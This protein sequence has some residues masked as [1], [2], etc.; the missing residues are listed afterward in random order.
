MRKDGKI[1]KI[2]FSRKRL[3]WI[4]DKY[5]NEGNYLSAL[6]MAYKE[7]DTFGGDGEVFVRLSDI[8]EGMNLQGMA[9]N[10]WF[11][12]LDIAE[13]DDLPDIYE[14]LAVNFLTLGQES[15]SA[16][17]YNRLIDADDTI[18]DETKLDIA[19]AFSTT[20]REK[21]RFVYP[22]HLAD[23]SKEVTIGAKALK[24]GDCERAVKELSKVEKGS[25][26]Y[27]QAKEMQAVAYLLASKVD[28][29][30]KACEEILS[31]CPDD[32]RA[33]ATLAAVYLEQGRG[34]KSKEIARI[35]S[36]KS[37]EDAD[38]LYKIA[39]V[40]C[41]N[42]LHEEAYQKFKILDKKTP[43]DGRILYFKGVS[44]Y[45][46]GRLDGAIAAF[47]TL[48][49]IYP[50]AEVAKY[51]LKQ[52]KECKEEGGVA[53]ELIYF[54]HLP[55]E[56]REQRCRA[57][58]KIGK[59]S[60]DEAQLFGLLAL[61]D[62][63]FR[64]CF[65]EMDGGDHELQYLGLV[66][67]IHVRAD[68]FVQD[69]LLDYEVADV[70][71]LEALRI[72]LERNEESEWGL[73]LCNIYKKVELLKVTLGRK[74]RKKF[75]EAYARLASKFVVIKDSYGA[76]IKAAT[77]ALY[78]ALENYGSLDL[79]DNADDCAC[80][81]FMMTGLKELGN[82]PALIAAAFDANVDKV[83]VLLSAAVSKEFGVKKD[84]NENN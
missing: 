5:Y 55:Q 54:Y 68:E 59:C 48:C 46:S 62:G 57:L 76:K 32:V 26:Q 51:Y 73:V 41:E 82:N 50:D 72:L 43:Y 37:V 81:I 22:P 38:E 64:W 63:Y 45:K 70:L 4:A 53:P 56:E 36:E 19:E 77:E 83:K 34:E 7:L 52:L 8:Y 1:K 66:T 42:G 11:R 58:I 13:T 33:L 80:A 23:Y 65:D 25:K 10:W 31:V 75:V 39:T 35:L 44:A 28:E 49:T 71:K 74:R 67:A 84:E 2:D 12:F 9:I 21:F 17:Y 14:G 47:E 16:Y 78:R 30:E 27:A 3:G 40:C 69:V 6:T 61:H 24:A 18:P 15:A 79:V 20:K 60:K 29:A